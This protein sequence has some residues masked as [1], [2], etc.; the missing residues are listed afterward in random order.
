MGDRIVGN[1]NDSRHVAAS[2]LCNPIVD[3]A[4]LH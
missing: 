2:R 3:E 1:E 4:M